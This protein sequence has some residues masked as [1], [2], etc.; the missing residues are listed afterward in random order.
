[1]YAL[2]N[3]SPKKHDVKVVKKSSPIKT[4]DGKDN[5]IGMAIKNDDHVAHQVIASKNVNKDN[6]DVRSKETLPK[7][8]LKKLGKRKEEKAQNEKNKKKARSENSPLLVSN[9]HL[10][11]EKNTKPVKGEKPNPSYICKYCCRRF[12]SSDQLREH[13]A[14]HGSNP[15]FICYMCGAETGA[16]SSLM[17]H[18]VK[19]SSKKN[20]LDKCTKFMIE[21]NNKELQISSQKSNIRCNHCKISF[22]TTEK[23]VSHFCSVSR[24]KSEYKCTYCGNVSFSVEEYRLHV[25][26]HSVTPYLCMHCNFKGPTKKLLDKH[27]ETCKKRPKNKKDGPIFKCK[28]CSME[29]IHRKELNQHF[30]F[31]KGIDCKAFFKTCSK[32]NCVFN[33]KR[34]YDSHK[35]KVF[36]ENTK[37]TQKSSQ[38]KKSIDK[39]ILRKETFLCSLCGDIFGSLREHEN[40]KQVCVDDHNTFNEKTSALCPTCGN[41]FQLEM[42]KEHMKTCLQSPDKSIRDSDVAKTSSDA[43]SHTTRRSARLVRRKSSLSEENSRCK[44]GRPKIKRFRKKVLKC[45]PGRKG[46][47]SK[48]GNENFRCTDCDLTFCSKSTLLRHKRMHSGNPYFSCKYCGKFFFRKDVYTRH[49]VNVHSKSSKNVFCCYYC[50][51]YF[52]DPPT[53]REHVLALHKENA[54]LP[55]RTERSQNI[56]QPIQ[57]KIE[58]DTNNSEVMGKTLETNSDAVDN[59]FFK[60]TSLTP[61]TFPLTKKCGTCLQSFGNISDIEKHMKSH[62]KVQDSTNSDTPLSNISNDN[63]NTSS[64]CV[65]QNT[66]SSVDLPESI[67][68][69]NSLN[70]FPSKSTQEKES[71][72]SLPNNN[73]SDSV[74][75]DLSE[76]AN[77]DQILS[78]EPTKFKCKLCLQEFQD[79]VLFESHKN[80]D[81]KLIDWYRCLI[82]ERIGPKQDMIDHMFAHMCKIGSFVINNSVDNVLPYLLDKESKE[83]HVTDHSNCITYSSSTEIHEIM[84]SELPP[85]IDSRLAVSECSKDKSSTPQS[86]CLIEEKLSSSDDVQVMQDNK[87]THSSEVDKCISSQRQSPN[88]EHSKNE[89]KCEENSDSSLYVES[90]EDACSFPQKAVNLNESNSSVIDIT[91]GENIK[92]TF[93]QF[94]PKDSFVQNSIEENLCF[95][96]LSSNKNITDNTNFSQLRYLLE[97]F[98]KKT[99]S[100]I[101]ENTEKEIDLSTF[102]TADKSSMNTDCAQLRHLLKNGSS[103]NSSN[104]N[105]TLQSVETQTCMKFSDRNLESPLKN[106]QDTFSNLSSESA[107]TKVPANFKRLVSQ[108]QDMN[109]SINTCLKFD[110]NQSG[111]EMSENLSPQ[112]QNLSSS[113]KLGRTSDI[114]PTNQIQSKILDFSDL[115]KIADSS[116]AN[117][118]SLFLCNEPLNISSNLSQTD[119]LFTFNCSPKHPDILKSPSNENFNELSEASHHNFYKISNASSMGAAMV[120]PNKS[121]CDSKGMFYGAS[122]KHSIPV[123]ID[124]T[125]NYKEPHH[126]SPVHG[127]S[128]PVNTQTPKKGKVKSCLSSEHLD[129]FLQNKC[130]KCGRTFRDRNECVKHY[131]NCVKSVW[132]S[133]NNYIN[134]DLKYPE[135][136]HSL[137]SKSETRTSQQI[138]STPSK[139]ENTCEEISNDSVLNL[140]RN[141]F[142]S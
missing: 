56:H 46:R 91:S 53:L 64:F 141:S 95:S 17:A 69:H 90:R 25:L 70:S 129:N 97:N 48:L 121:T 85:L 51:L 120:N 11:V 13:V 108:Q 57:I 125:E 105:R 14:S 137:L 103:N 42:M 43:D 132:T 89:N 110:I 38:K 111:C 49:E 116:G 47:Q 92:E 41:I 28:K 4:Q 6:I 37:I 71:Y 15:S 134:D 33:N 76:P 118:D 29:F 102:Q 138:I 78:S 86:Q 54:F 124:C 34:D 117:D 2:K 67:A 19:H 35:C 72:V 115:L 5:L 30:R 112:K 7:Q 55:A 140:S 127:I 100:D 126:F 133:K 88:K 3:F 58:P 65:N 68:N 94:L 26:S 24:K 40:H 101:D 114:F 10:K 84:D 63:V 123:E 18:C 62:K 93:Q 52:A 128:P 32:C 23:L 113:S 39:V 16:F 45:V 79:A 61:S 60:N 135:T 83:V 59:D 139:S 21:T 77:Q 31:C 98:K 106:S 82:C 36:E 9:D 107:I 50:R 1:M 66:E 81:H 96:N 8:S 136:L 12:R 27:L 104:F 119:S 142:N 109:Q 130:N 73:G 99:N 122:N 22:P 20:R 75:T 131:V 74:N 44:E 87:L 80:F